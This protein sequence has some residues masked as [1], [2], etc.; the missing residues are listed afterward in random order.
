MPNKKEV[1]LSSSDTQGQEEDFSVTFASKENT[2]GNETVILTSEDIA[3]E[4]MSKALQS[5]DPSNGQ[6][7]VYLKEQPFG[8]D[9]V[10]LDDIKLL[11]KNAQSDITKILKI[12]AL[13]RQEINGDDIIGKVYETMVTISI[14]ILKYHSITFH[15]NQSRNTRIKQNHLLNNSIGKQI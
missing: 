15:Q 9:S 12:N 3:K 8:D 4:W 6:Y 7:S 13:V 10:T 2:D 14:L 1:V 11:S 5:F